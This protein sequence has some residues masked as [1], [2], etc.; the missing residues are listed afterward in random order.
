MWTGWLGISFLLVPVPAWWLVCVLALPPVLAAVSPAAEISDVKG[1]ATYSMPAVQSTD[2]P[3]TDTIETKGEALSSA[4]CGSSPQEENP[5]GF[6]IAKLMNAVRIERSIK[7]NSKHSINKASFIDSTFLM[8]IVA[9]VLV[10]LYAIKVRTQKYT[11]DVGITTALA[12]A[13][14]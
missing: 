8:G 1:T 13:T 2:S 14:L 3:T 4:T 12:I 5:D 11:V 7:S 10:M 6:D 9:T